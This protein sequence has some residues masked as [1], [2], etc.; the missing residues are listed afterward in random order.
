MRF[1]VGYL[2]PVH[3]NRPTL[4][5]CGSRHGRNGVGIFSRTLPELAEYGKIGR[6]KKSQEEKSDGR[7]LPALNFM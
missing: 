1:G 6:W 3:R 5:S 7:L 4:E 2:Y